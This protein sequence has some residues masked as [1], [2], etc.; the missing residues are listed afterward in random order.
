MHTDVKELKK[1]VREMKQ[2]LCE[3]GL[4]CLQ[5]LQGNAALLRAVDLISS[6][7]ALLGQEV[8][9]NKAEIVSKIDAFALAI[10]GLPE[11]IRALAVGPLQAQLDA[12]T[13]LLHTL[14][15][16]N[17]SVPTLAIVLPDVSHKGRR[18]GKMDPREWS[19]IAQNKYRLS[20]ICSHTLQVR[21]S[22][23]YN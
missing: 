14:I 20:F 19:R 1:E 17:Y 8:A 10:Q 6:D 12:Q 23:S 7:V 21:G 9:A 11:A 13:A 5:V 15:K 2:Q 22:V 16:D 4:Q 3:L 18:L